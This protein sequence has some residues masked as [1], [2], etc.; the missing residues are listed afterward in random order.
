MKR[1]EFAPSKDI[2]HIFLIGLGFAAFA[3]LGNFLP[4]IIESLTNES[5]VGIE[6]YSTLIEI[7]NHLRPVAF[8][9]GS[10]GTL[11]TYFYLFRKILFP[12]N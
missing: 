3:T 9:V 10:F 1:H 8:L 5:E 11:T 4:T 12:F 7:A 6:L 2:V